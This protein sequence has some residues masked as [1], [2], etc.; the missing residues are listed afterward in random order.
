MLNIEELTAEARALIDSGE[1]TSDLFLLEIVDEVHA[2]ERERAEFRG[3]CSVGCS[4]ANIVNSD[5]GPL[6]RWTRLPCE[7]ARLSNLIEL[8]GSI[9]QNQ[10]PSLIEGVH[11]D[12]HLSR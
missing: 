3:C 7:S 12:H 2:T 10:T 8:Y 4:S 11:C 6:C 1:K 9:N 5:F